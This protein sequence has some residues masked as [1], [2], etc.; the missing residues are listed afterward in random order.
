MGTRKKK[1]NNTQINEINE[2]EIKAKNSSVEHTNTDG[3]KAKRASSVQ[4]IETKIQ[5]DAITSM[6]MLL[7]FAEG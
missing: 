1:K 7:L 3:I 5:L 2:N 6:Y 4:S